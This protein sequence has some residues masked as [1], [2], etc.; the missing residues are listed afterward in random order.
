MTHD[1]SPHHRRS[2]RLKGYDYGRMG[3]Y[4]ITICTQDRACLFG[5][6][7][8]GRM[9]LNE[10][11]AIVREEWFR[12]AQIRQEIELSAE[13]FVVMPNHIHGIVWIVDSAGAGIGA[14]GPGGAHGR[15]PLHRQPRSL[16]SF[17]A[18]FKSAV[19]KRIN[20]HR[21]T[22]GASVWQRNYYEHIVRNEE[23]L[24]R[25]REYILTNPLRWHLDQENPDRTGKDE[26]WDSLFGQVGAGTHGGVPLQGT[27]M[28]E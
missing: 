17:I 6:V 21:D 18:G 10:C 7:V 9:Q 1:K 20:E 13:E 2:I 16:A 23:S 14:P 26:V 22:P 27:T 15:A 3:A 12:S 19:T 11:G 25:I 28:T 8:D 4:F 24:A 5:T